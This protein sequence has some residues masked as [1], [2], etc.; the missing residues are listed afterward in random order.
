M[1]THGLSQDSVQQ[2]DKYKKRMLKTGTCMEEMAWG[3][4]ALAAI[5][6]TEVGE[7]FQQGQMRL[8]ET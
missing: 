3:D 2:I 7:T 6:A 1:T 5:E 8:G 4:L